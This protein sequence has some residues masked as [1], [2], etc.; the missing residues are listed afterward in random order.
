M[1]GPRPT[2]TSRSA[3]ARLA[4]FA[5]LA[6]VLAAPASLADPKAAA[7]EPAG[8][9]FT[10]DFMAR[11]IPVWTELF[12]P[13]AG[14]K[15]LRY[16]EVGV[17]EGRSFV[18]M[19]DNV[20]T[21]PS[22]EAWAVDL[23]NGPFY[24]LFLRNLLAGGHATK[25]KIRR[26]DS[27]T[28]LPTLPADS[29]DIVYIDGNHE[30]QYVLSD[31]V[32][33]WELLEEGGLLLFDDYRLDL[34]VGRPF[35]DHHLPGP[36]IDAFVSLYAEDIELVHDGYQKILRK[37]TSRCDPIG[38]SAL[39]PYS[40]QW[41]TKKLTKGPGSSPVDLEDAE[42]ELLERF[43]RSRL[44]GETR[45]SPPPELLASP[46]WKGLVQRLGLRDLDERIVSEEELRAHRARKPSDSY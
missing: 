14:R 42:R 30:G 23:F 7:G 46:A 11:A 34:R 12:A 17:F 39:G 6:L 43:L 40:Y 19:L 27:R 1:P 28:V 38:C 35:P 24:D 16:L 4:S 26:G 3:H 37:R 20:L 18:W 25:T 21:D 13:Y 31:A 5:A 44:P 15:D 9:H 8:Y 32:M 29:F 2:A 10:Q 45:F 41:Y 33:A 22:C 36:A